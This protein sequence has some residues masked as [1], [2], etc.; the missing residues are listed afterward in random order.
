M[1]VGFRKSIYDEYAYYEA[2]AEEICKQ[3]IAHEPDSTTAGQVG[4][5]VLLVPASQAPTA[6]PDRS[7]A[8]P[9]GA[10]T[11]L[12]D[13]SCGACRR[14]ETA[15]DAMGAMIIDEIIIQE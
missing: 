2:I 3:I 14:C 10:R 13:K 12:Y 1:S 15:W 11:P 7:T 8:G 4:S 6:Q 9:I 5:S